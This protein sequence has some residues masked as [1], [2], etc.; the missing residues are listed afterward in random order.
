MLLKLDKC[1]ELGSVKID[2]IELQDEI[3]VADIMELPV[4]PEKWG[5][6]VSSVSKLS[7]QPE[8]VIRK[9]SARDFT[10]AC[11]HVASFLSGG[12]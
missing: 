12:Q 2:E 11:E 1:I 4:Q 7:G 10:L 9:M 6:Y 3:T 5:A 8:T